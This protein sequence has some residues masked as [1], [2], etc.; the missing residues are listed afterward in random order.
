MLRSLM[1]LDDRVDI[2]SSVAL[3]T[4]MNAARQILQVLKDQRSEALWHKCFWV[5]ERFLSIGGDCSVQDISND[6]SLPAI[7]I[8]AYHHG[9]G[10]TRQMAENLNRGLATE[11]PILPCR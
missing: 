3:L 7:L 1:L 8:S 9:D 4:E 2:D 11:L 6:R 10:D 5:L